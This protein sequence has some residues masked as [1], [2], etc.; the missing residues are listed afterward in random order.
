MD[1]LQKWVPPQSYHQEGL[2]DQVLLEQFLANSEEETQKWVR[3][4][5]PKNSEEALQLAEAFVVS[6][7]EY[8]RD[9]SFRNNGGGGCQEEEQHR[10]TGRGAIKNV[11]CYWCNHMGHISKECTQASR[12]QGRSWGFPVIHKEKNPESEGVKAVDCSFGCRDGITVWDYPMI[13][14]WIEGKPIQ[15]TLDTGCLQTLIRAD[16][17]PKDKIQWTNPV[18]MRCLHRGLEEYKRGFVNVEIANRRGKM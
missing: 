15:A 5:S 12:E 4:H 3:C 11:L 9:R 13:T 14:V 17:V 7:G 1:L 10:D 18:H 8:T 2:A 16:M 6:E